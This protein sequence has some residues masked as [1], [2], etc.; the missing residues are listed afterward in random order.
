[1]IYHIMDRDEPVIDIETDDKNKVI[2]FKKYRPDKPGQIFWGSNITTE[3]FFNFLKS[4]CYEDCRAD[5]PD[6][7]E[8]H[9]LESNNPYEW[10]RITHGVTYEDFIWIRYDNEKIEWKDVRIR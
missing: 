9:G 6:I 2:A 5:L 7:L 8:Y 1:M 10:N 3:R 4:R